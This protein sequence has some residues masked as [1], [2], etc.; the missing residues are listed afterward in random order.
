MIKHGQQPELI[1][2]S[3]RRSE[4]AEKFISTAHG[5]KRAKGVMQLLVLNRPMDQLA[6]ADR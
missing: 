6:L 1:L 5:G 4:D 2:S 3:Q